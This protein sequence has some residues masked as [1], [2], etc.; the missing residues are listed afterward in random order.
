MTDLIQLTIYGIVLGSIFALGA[1]GLSLIYAILR[2][3]HFAHGDFMTLGAYISLGIVTTFGIPPIIALPFGA[4]GAVLFAIAIDQT[5]YRR[6]RKTQPVILLISSVGT[7]LILRALLQMVFGSETQ[8]YQ[9]GIQMPYRFGDFRIKPAHFMIVGIAAALVLA[10]HL[11]LQKTRV[12]KAMRAMSDNRDLAQVTGISVDR[13]V[14]WTWGIG[15][16]LAATAG[17]LLG[18]DT[19]L[20]PTMGWNILLPVFAAAILGGIGSP[21]GA[22]AGGLV[23]GI[24]QEWSTTFISPAYKPAVAFAIMVLMLLVRPTG[25]F[26]GRKV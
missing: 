23:I 1:V 12:G 25:L 8:V 24:V 17:V 4:A 26:S 5:I 19:R 7:A 11:F 18:M 2:F 21:Y 20:H 3:P 15:I 13:I 9:S 16:A 14:V 22:I 10:L 6:L